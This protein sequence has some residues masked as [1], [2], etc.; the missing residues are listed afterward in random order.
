MHEKADEIMNHKTYVKASKHAD[1][2]VWMRAE[3]W[4]PIQMAEVSLWAVCACKPVP[5]F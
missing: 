2:W 1:N 4:N 3:E 5:V